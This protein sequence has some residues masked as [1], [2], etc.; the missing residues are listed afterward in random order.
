MMR[1]GGTP[2]AVGGHK[3]T[4]HDRRA[5]HV[6]PFR[7]SPHNDSARSLLRIEK[8]RYTPTAVAATSRA[9]FT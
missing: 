4:R 2:S 9:G 1:R 3:A 6:F 5:L 7:H 8:N